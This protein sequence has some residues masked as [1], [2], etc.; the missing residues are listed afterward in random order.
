MKYLAVVIIFVCGAMAICPTGYSEMLPQSQP[1]AE[2]IK[3]GNE[4]AVSSDGTLWRAFVNRTGYERWQK[5]AM[6]SGM[7]ADGGHGYANILQSVC[8]TLLNPAMPRRTLRDTSKKLWGQRIDT[9]GSMAFQAYSSLPTLV[10]PLTT[11]LKYFK[12]DGVA[13]SGTFS[14]SSAAL[15]Q[16]ASGLWTQA[17]VNIPRFGFYNSGTETM[18]VWTKGGL[19]SEGNTTNLLLYSEQMDNSVWNKTN[20]TVM[21]NRASAPVFGLATTADR[22]KPKLGGAVFQKYSSASPLTQGFYSFSLMAICHVPALKATLSLRKGSGAFANIT[23]TFNQAAYRRAS[24]MK[25]MT[26]TFRSIEARITFTHATSLMTVWGAQLENNQSPTSYIPTAGATATRTADSLTVPAAGNMDDAA[27]SLLLTH[28]PQLTGIGP[29][30]TYSNLIRWSNA[31]MSRALSSSSITAN[32]GTTQVGAPI[33][34]GWSARD[35]RLAL[36]WGGGNMKI[37]DLNDNTSSSALYDGSWNGAASISVGSYS[38]T[39]SCNGFI[40]DLRIW[41]SKLLDSEVSAL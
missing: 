38:G 17:A 10:M 2:A 19:L 30:S 3:L 8:G 37:Y 21:S 15:Y 26:G 39:N 4:Y 34:G 28:R 6:P 13:G 20:A 24:V 7:V 9:T 16:D 14:R 40:R 11:D 29:T 31:V 22:I 23:A 27:G 41:T 35:Y 18:P 36:T 25:N 32:D 5:S 12:K 33:V 1:V